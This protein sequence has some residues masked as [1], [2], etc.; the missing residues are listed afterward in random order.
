LLRQGN[1]EGAAAEYREAIRIA[2]RDPQARLLAQVLKYASIEGEET[3]RIALRKESCFELQEAAKLWYF[4]NFI[5]PMDRV[6]NA[7]GGF[8][9]CDFLV[10][11]GPVD[12]E[13]AAAFQ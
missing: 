5:E 10:G 13:K 2:P 4:D 8:G 9:R 11:V 12:G 3:H 1:F 7:L 6:N